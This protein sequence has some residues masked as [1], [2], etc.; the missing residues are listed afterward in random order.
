MPPPPPRA[1]P[2]A[3]AHR[4]PGT[5]AIS[6]GLLGSKA[7]QASRRPW[8]ND[9]TT[10]S[11]LR[12][13][14]MG[15]LAGEHPERFRVLHLVGGLLEIGE[16]L[17]PF[18]QPFPEEPV[19]RFPRWPVVVVPRI[20]LVLGDLILCPIEGIDASNGR[21]FH[22]GGRLGPIAGRRNHQHRPGRHQ[23]AD[24]HIRGRKSDQRGILAKA[25]PLHRVRDHI[26]RRPHLDPGVHRAKRKRLGAPARGPGTTRS[27]PDPRTAGARDNPPPAGSTRAGARTG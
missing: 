17:R 1:H 21:V 12:A 9:A 8:I 16:F 24:L 2:R 27:A 11:G 22:L 14:S 25:P 18:K 26:H 10:S 23:R 5:P 3:P 13:P 7:A 19:N 20:H 4:P 15:S 6:S